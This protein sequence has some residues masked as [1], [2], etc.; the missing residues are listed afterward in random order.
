VGVRLRVS[1]RVDVGVRVIVRVR[2]S[3]GVDDGVRVR[4]PVRVMVGLCVP[5]GDGVYR[6]GYR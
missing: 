6:W 5:V 4:V 3:V 1:V 2:V